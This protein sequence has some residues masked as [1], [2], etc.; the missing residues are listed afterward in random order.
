MQDLEDLLGRP[1]EVT[2]ASDLHWIV[3]PQ[4]IWEAVPL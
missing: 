1:V 3:R 2:T 4:A